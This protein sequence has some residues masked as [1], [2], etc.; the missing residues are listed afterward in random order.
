LGARELVLHIRLCEEKTGSNKTRE[1]KQARKTFR[2][3]ALIRVQ[4]VNFNCVANV[5][6]LL[7]LSCAIVPSHVILHSIQFPRHIVR[8]TV[9]NAG[10]ACIVL[11]AHFEH[12][13][14]SL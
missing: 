1:T 6:K 14:H 11:C 13:P 8:P 7:Q 10:C 5:A 4:P 12:L 9:N 2:K 3:L